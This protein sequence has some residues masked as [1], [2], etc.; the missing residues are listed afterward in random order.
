MCCEAAAER[1]RLRQEGIH[2]PAASTP[3]TLL[4]CCRDSPLLYKAGGAYLSFRVL[5]EELHVLLLKSIPDCTH[6]R[7]GGTTVS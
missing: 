2:L 1:V 3:P 5:F 4:Q 7:E 6:D